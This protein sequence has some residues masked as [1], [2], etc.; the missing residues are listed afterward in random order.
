MN[1]RARHAGPLRRIAVVAVVALVAAG[2]GGDSGSRDR[3]GPRVGVVI[4]G[5][6]NPFLAAMK[7]GVL[8]AAHD[9][10]ADLRLSAATGLEDTAGQAASSRRS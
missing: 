4:K 2:C 6:G 10:K 9:R 3:G 7:Q 5:L 1:R 8:A